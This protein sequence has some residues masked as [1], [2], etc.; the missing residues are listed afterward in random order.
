M[1]K[2]KHDSTNA[3][4]KSLLKPGAH[5]NK[6]NNH[7]QNALQCY[8]A[9]SPFVDMEIA[10]LLLAARETIEPRTIVEGFG[11]SRCSS[12]TADVLEYLKQDEQKL[13]LM[14]V[15]RETIRNCLLQISAINFCR[16]PN[17][18]LPKSLNNYLLYDV[19]IEGE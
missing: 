18:G 9:G 13:N 16:V 5:V 12:R 6:T 10:K 14:H 3:I 1:I 8:L 19:S 4:V 11:M 15:C 17:L 7:H 2:E